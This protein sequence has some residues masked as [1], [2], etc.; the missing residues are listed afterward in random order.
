MS[1]EAGNAIQ[2]LKRGKPLAPAMLDSRHQWT[3]ALEMG[4]Q[5]GDFG[6][7]GD[8][9]TETMPRE[10]TEAEALYLSFPPQI[11]FS[12][13]AAVFEG[14]APSL[15]W[16]DAGFLFPREVATRAV[17]EVL[18][19]WWRAIHL[20]RTPSASEKVLG[21]STSLVL[22]MRGFDGKDF[23][24]SIPSNNV[25]P[26]CLWAPRQVMMCP[27]AKFDP[28]IGHWQLV[29]FGISQHLYFQSIHLFGNITGNLY[30]PERLPKTMEVPVK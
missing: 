6:V 14:T 21:E 9:P 12:L 20:A 22:H 23:E 19:D 11:P 5:S 16:S 26:G 30:G 27:K 25:G 1:A 7:S 10:A 15:F 28:Q 2:P 3:I 24:M 29:G 13:Y 18:S 4:F 17:E 8:D